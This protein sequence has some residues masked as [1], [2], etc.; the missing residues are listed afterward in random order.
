MRAQH[1]FRILT[2]VTSLICLAQTLPALAQEFKADTPR[3]EPEVSQPAGERANATANASPSATTPFSPLDQQSQ[4]Q[5]QSQS[6]RVLNGSVSALGAAEVPSENRENLSIEI[7]GN[8]L[9]N[10]INLF[11]GGRGGTIRLM[12]QKPKLTSE[13]YRAM[14]YGVL[15][16]NVVSHTDS[17]CPVVAGVYPTCP[18]ALAGI[19]P[20]DLMV[21]ANGHVFQP[22]EGQAAL[23][24]IV[25]GKAD[26]PVCLT[27]MRQG[28]LIDLNLVRMNIEDIMDDNI[29]GTYED[30]ISNLGAPG[31]NRAYLNQ[32]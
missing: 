10:L 16:M 30:L 18:A 27:I 26:T 19:M 17:P 9:R 3:L 4:S 1:K 12:A 32:E 21:K 23:W 15:G 31:E 13:Q 24:H 5:I 6:Q 8:Q 29:R 11:M 14:N 20:G 25:C 2:A 22:G 7:N 28:R